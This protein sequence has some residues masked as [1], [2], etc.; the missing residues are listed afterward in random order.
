M[1]QKGAERNM[2]ISRIEVLFLL[3]FRPK[4]LIERTNADY[5][6]MNTPE[7]IQLKQ[8]R[9]QRT[10]QAARSINKIR[11]SLFWSLVLVA[12]AVLAAGVIGKA[13]FALGGARCQTAEEILQYS[14]IGILL[15]AT[16]GKAGWSVQTMNGD[17][18]PELV[19]EWVFRALYVLG[20]FLLALAVSLT[21]GAS[22]I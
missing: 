16:L 17:T 6:E 18:I 4:K 15:W 13:Y 19:N 7:A 22:N 10:T 20:S 1:L 14:G 2:K 3:V 9:N 8:E 5:K 12:G 21:F 11:S